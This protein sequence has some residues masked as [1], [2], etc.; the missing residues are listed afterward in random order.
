MKKKFQISKIKKVIKTN[1]FIYICFIA[2][3]IS[4]IKFA[5]SGANMI[6]FSK[7]VLNMPAVFLAYIDVLFSFSQLIASV[8]VGTYFIKKF[9]IEKILI[10][11]LISNLIFYIIILFSNNYLY[12]FFGYI[13]NGFGY[14]IGYTSVVSMSMQ[15]FEKEDRNISMGIFQAFFALG[16]FF[17]DRV[18]MW[19]LKLIPN[20]IFLLDV[21]KS[22]YLIIIVINIFSIILANFKVDKKII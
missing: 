19:I 13:F 12:A 15:Y 11:G 18:Y 6:A 20:G 3:L 2:V 5:S 21:N 8:L 16:V 17:G 10:L 22:I 9:S 4:F 7:T 14:G 1:N